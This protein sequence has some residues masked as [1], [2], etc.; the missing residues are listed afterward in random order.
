MNRLCALVQKRRGA[1]HQ[2]RRHRELRRDL[3]REV[4]CDAQS[5]RRLALIQHARS[6]RRHKQDM[7]ALEATPFPDVA[8]AY[9]PLAGVKHSRFLPGFVFGV[10]KKSAQ[11]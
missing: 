5:S 4:L 1:G 6:L 8:L 9:P 7:R 2:L 11:L 3:R 10:V